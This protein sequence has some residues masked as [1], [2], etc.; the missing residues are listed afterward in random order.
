MFYNPAKQA[1]II[2]CKTSKN[3]NTNEPDINKRFITTT[4]NNNTDKSNLISKLETNKTI[5]KAK[6]K[7]LFNTNALAGFVSDLFHNRNNNK[8]FKLRTYFL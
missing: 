5:T 3:N 8:D 1:D 2:A 4:I 7:S 6:K